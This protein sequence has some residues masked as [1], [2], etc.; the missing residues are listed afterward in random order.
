[1]TVV[2]LDFFFCKRFI[3]VSIMSREASPT[4]RGSTDSPAGLDFKALI[5][6]SLSELLRESPALFQPP[7]NPP[8]QVP[9]VASGKENSL[10]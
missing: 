6:A 8:P 3:A 10:V 2:L 5:K 9:A 1:M 4:P 7:A